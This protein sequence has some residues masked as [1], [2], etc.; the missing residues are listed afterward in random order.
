MGRKT[1]AGLRNQS[2]ARGGFDDGANLS[3]RLC[4]HHFAPQHGMGRN[5]QLAVH[6]VYGEGLAGSGLVGNDPRLMSVSTVCCT[7]RRRG[8]APKAGS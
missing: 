6:T 4:V 8:R 2:G 7:K 1:A 3:G 5:G